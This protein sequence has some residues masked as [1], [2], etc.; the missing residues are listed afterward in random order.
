[1]QWPVAL[2]AAA[3]LASSADGGAPAAEPQ[4]SAAEL[5]TR[6]ERAAA[7]QD[8]VAKHYVLNAEVYPFWIPGTESFWYKRQTDTGHRFVVFDAA[9]G[10]RA[11]A[12]DHARLA[13]QLAKA[14]GTEVDAEDLPIVGLSLTPPPR[15]ASFTSRGRTW[16]YDVTRDALAEDTG[17][18]KDR[19]SLLISPDGTKALFLKDSNLWVRDLESGR[20]R[21]L[22]TDG[23]RYYAYA[24]MPDVFDRPAARPEAVWS[25]DS[26]RVF[27]AQVDDRQV[28]DMP[29]IDFAP[30]DGSVRPTTRPVRMAL[31][32]DEHVTGFRLVVIEAATGKQVAA[33]YPVNPVARMYD[34]PFGGGRAWW[35]ADGSVAYVV[36]IER[37]ERTVRVVAIDAAT[38]AT[39]TVLEEK[40]ESYVELGSNVGFPAS[41]VP[42]PATDEMVWYSE[43]SG[44][45]HLYLYDLRTGALKRQLTSGE[46]LVRD[47]VAVDAAR[48]D[49]VVTIAGRVPGRNPYYREIARVNLDSGELTVLSSSDADHKLRSSRE[50]DDDVLGEDTE[51]LSGVSPSGEYLV[52]TVTR[53]DGP[54]RTALLRRDGS[55][56]AVVEAADA[57]RLPKG[58]TWPEPVLLK[59]ADGTTDIAAVVFRPSDFSPDRRYPVID[60]IYGGPQVSAVPESFAP[61]MLY[62]D[63]VSFAELGFVA[64]IVDGRG[65]AERSRAFHEAS[66]GAAHTA[67][68]LEDHIAAIRQLAERFRYLDPERVGIFGFSGGGYMAAVAMLRFPD[69][70]KVAVA[71][72]GNYDQ[73]LFVHTWGE[74]YQGPLEGD[75]Y[76]PQAALTYARNLKGK[77]MFIHGLADYG[78]HPAGLFQLI[79]ALIEAGKDFD[80]TLQP[81]VGHEMGGWAQRRQWDYFVRNLAGL[82]PPPPV[83]H[84]SA[85]ELLDERIMK[86]MSAAE[87]PKKE[88]AAAEKAGGEAKN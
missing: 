45:A 71:G 39:S 55:E 20:E 56:A 24:G 31:P 53:A 25:P 34:T 78:V 47:L 40:A 64:V 50:L 72:S 52:E 17:A 73:R 74:R 68:N 35:S 81:R 9:T 36:E 12:F 87:E 33:H 66:Y 19:K 70:F 76:L 28:K 13:A 44:W 69:F 77:L 75:S 15:T 46:W 14:T 37:G 63:A 42:L 41:I 48:R 57:S 29:V 43:R 83:A 1:L 59:G 84:K 2:L 80:L 38:G 85:W 62:L 67:S 32:G 27:T 65:T 21:A 10:M 8:H 22:T 5:R 26:T 16:R 58:W 23:A 11:E 61:T 82:E 54:A 79:Q 88:P 18:I 3:C 86:A 4:P 51:R 7:W 30:A 60:C 49:L 6:Y